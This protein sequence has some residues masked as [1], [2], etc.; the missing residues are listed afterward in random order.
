MWGYGLDRAGSG[1]GQVAGTCDCGNDPSGSIKC[2]EFLD[3]LRTGQLLKKNYAPWSKYVS[4]F[5]KESAHK[6]VFGNLWRRFSR[7]WAVNV[8][9]D[10]TE[11]DVRARIAS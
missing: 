2:G 10:L 6:F 7:G 11:I 1:Q 9:M 3:Q 4:E 5:G 8:K